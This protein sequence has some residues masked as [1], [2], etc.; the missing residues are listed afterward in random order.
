MDPLA[1]LTYHDVTKHRPGRYAPSLGYLDWETQPDPFRRWLEAP[2]VLLPLL[3]RDP[4]GQHLDLYQRTHNTFWDFNLESIGAFLELSMGLSAWKS[5]GQSRWAL[6]MNPSSGNLHPTE[7]H[8]ILPPLTAPSRLTAKGAPALPGDPIE[9]GR[10]G[11]VYHYQPYLHALEQRAVLSES[12]GQR[13]QSHFQS[14]GFLVVLTSIVWREAWKYGARAYRYCQH[15]AGHALGAMSFASNLLGWKVTCLNAVSDEQA[16]TVLGF[17][18]TV[19]PTAEEEHIDL[20]C[21][22]SPATQKAISRSLP[23]DF[24][25]AFEKVSFTGQPSQLSS[26]HVDWDAINDVL[27]LMEKPETHEASVRL[28]S[29][30]LF[31]P[32]HHQ[33]AAHLIRQRRSAVAYDG[34]TG[35]TS[36]QMLAI[37]D[38]T[39]PRLNAAPFDVELGAARVHLALFVHRVHQW[40]PGLY[41]LV[42]NSDA[43]ADLK[44]NLSRDFKWEA[45]EMGYPLY[46]LKEGDF[47]LDAG[48]ISCHQAIASKSAFSLGMISRFLPEIEKTP[49]VYRTLFQECG[50]IGQALYLESEAQGIRGTGIG[51]F[52]DDE[53][54]QLLG[55]TTNNYQSLYHFTA[56]GPLEDA[57]LQ[58]QPAYAH[59][60][61]DRR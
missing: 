50:L 37:L 39:L 28:E 16:C 25:K 51:C 45:V 21:Y 56:G 43:L 47:Q 3:K 26:N 6:R 60:P 42:R 18:R 41:L 27:P 35:I 23:P 31:P 11:G 59:L 44:R 19:W 9:P 12:Y 30:P 22:V 61:A 34:Q 7:A 49:W 57:R 24:V 20:V 54:H 15:D 10:K 5:V 17:D 14:P 8:L 1:V 58:T 55:I 40:K 2:V 13:M 48:Q 53:M 46:L 4:D 36:Q 38:R 33:F 52:F 29:R 32:H